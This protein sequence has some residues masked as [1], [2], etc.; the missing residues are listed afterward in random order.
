MRDW[1]LGLQKAAI[2]H[3]AGANFD[4]L[5]AAERDAGY[6][7]PDELKELYGQMNGAT[8]ASG[9]VLYGLRGSGEVKG[10]LE[11]N[12]SGN[13]GLPTEEI[14]RFGRK[15]QEHLAAIRNRRIS[16]IDQAEGSA[17]PDWLDAAS[18]DRWLFISRDESANALRVYPTLE[19]LIRS[20]VPPAE[21]EDFGDR[22]FARALSLVESAI[23]EIGASAK[24]RVEKVT[25][26]IRKLVADQ[27]KKRKP[28]AKASS[29]VKRTSAKPVAAK[30]KPA[31]ASASAKRTAAKKVANTKP[32][33][34]SS[35][36]K[37]TTS[38]PV[39]KRKPAKSSGAAKRTAAKPIG[40]KK[41]A[42]AS[43]SPGLKTKS[44]K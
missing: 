3:R 36:S 43:A 15:D 42:K 32:A 25:T 8:F 13:S 7:L 18:D 14:W 41:P 21:T 28:G 44:A 20:R 30:K 16:E 19:Q 31:K 34:S 11:Q 17:P 37:R 23:E 9:V 39:A 4:E 26:R 40:K 27:G 12:R 1:I 22:T 35:A 5:A 38:K 6:E 10:M 29:A 2:E 24:E 33:K